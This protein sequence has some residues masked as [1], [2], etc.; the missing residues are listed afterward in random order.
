MAVQGQNEAPL[1][2][3][4]AAHAPPRAAMNDRIPIALPPAQIQQAPNRTDLA[5]IA[6]SLEEEYQ[7]GFL[8]HQ[9]KRHRRYVVLRAQELFNRLYTI[10]VSQFQANYR[11]FK[12]VI[13]AFP[14]QGTYATHL[15]S[16]VACYISSWFWDLYVSNRESVQKLSSTAFLQ[17]YSAEQHYSQDRYDPF[18]QHLNNVIKPTHIPL[19][20]EDTLY[21]PQ[22]AEYIDFA[23]SSPFGITGFV[24]NEALVQGLLDTMDMKNN[25]WR[26]VPLAHDTLGRPMWLLDWRLN[27]GYAWFPQEGHFAKEDLVAAQ[28]LGIPCTPRLAPRDVDDW[29][30]FPGNVLPQNLNANHFARAIPRRFYGAAEYRTLSHRIWTPP[31]DLITATAPAGSKRPMPETPSGRTSGSGIMEITPAVETRTMQQPP[32]AAPRPAAYCQYQLIDWCYHGLV[33]I[34]VNTQKQNQA[35]RSFLYSG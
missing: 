29:Q 35:I 20:L 8:R 5:R 16:A 18:L 6:D 7:I 32:D 21:I 15:N 31:F 11:A 33:V 10:Y 4:A 17:Y 13:E 25:T 26:T 1:Q 24:I 28:I 30:F 14:L 9:P 27:Q 2:A 34:G 3:Q 22:L 23:E 19:G 12:T